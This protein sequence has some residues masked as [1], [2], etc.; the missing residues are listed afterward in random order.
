MTR[1]RRQRAGYQAAA[2]LVWLGLYGLLLAAYAAAAWWL[3][4]SG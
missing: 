4:R 2:L 3:L 1:W